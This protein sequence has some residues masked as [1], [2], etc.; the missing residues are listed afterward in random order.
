MDATL[1]LNGTE[2]NANMQWLERRMSQGVAQ[3]V[4]PTIGGGAI[5]VAQEITEGKHITLVSGDDFGMLTKAQVDAV[6]ELAEEPGGVFMLELEYGSTVES[7]SVVFRHDDPPA[8]DASP[9]IP[10][11]VSDATDLF[12][13]QIKLMIV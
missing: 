3:S 9:L 1:T 10:R 5:V 12:R 2:L 4:T 6:K 7:Y 8:F 13:A 11:I